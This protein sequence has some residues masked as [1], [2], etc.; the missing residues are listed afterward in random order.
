MTDPVGTI[1][2]VGGPA[3][4]NDIDVAYTG[5]SKFLARLQQLSDL[6]DANETAYANL[7]L[8]NDAAAA[9]RNAQDKQRDATK[10]L[11]AAQSDAQATRVA[12]AKVKA[13]ADAYVARVSAEAD[14]KSAQADK[15]NAAATALAA[16]VTARMT[17]QQKAIAD[18]KAAKTSADKAT[19][20][21]TDKTDRLRALVKELAAGS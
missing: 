15:T 9:L 7:Q 5:G 4:S 6:R 20:I 8:G 16:T 13:D 1:G 18:A 10:A 2:T 11:E 3:E 17:E 19:A 12:A 21:F 14:A